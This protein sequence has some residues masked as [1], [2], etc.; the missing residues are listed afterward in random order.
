MWNSKQR[1]LKKRQFLRG[2]LD[3]LSISFLITK[4]AS[5]Q[6]ETSACGIYQESPPKKKK[7]KLGLETCRNKKIC[8]R[9]LNTVH[10][11]RQQLLLLCAHSAPRDPDLLC[12][13]QG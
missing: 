5:S 9:E 3:Q 12:S 1:P 6:A 2:K 4:G 7:Q 8:L 10:L 13:R 11:L